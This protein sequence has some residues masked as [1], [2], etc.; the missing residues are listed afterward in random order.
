VSLRL[1]MLQARK[2]LLEQQLAGY[3]AVRG[4]HEATAVR[5]PGTREAIADLEQQLS[6]LAAQL[7]RLELRATRAGTV[8]SPPNVPRLPTQP[9]ALP[10]WD[11]SPLDVANQGCYLETG[12]PV[13]LVGHPS[14]VSATVLIPQAELPFVRLGQR[15]ELL[16][17]GLSD[18]TLPGVVAEISPVPVDVLPR[19]LAARNALPIDPNALQTPQ[20]M[21]PVYRVRVTLEP[22]GAAPPLRWATG[23]ARIRL[24]SE[25]LAYR[26][27]RGARRTFH[28]QL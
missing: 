8:L 13:C 22:V 4:E 23:E 20:P 28:F 25:P 9:D 1:A 10:L 6:T 27:W 11:G 14:R 12:S 21:E 19:E 24:A 26:L 7:R 3:L 5:I 16:L 15:V 17:S 18:R 2:R